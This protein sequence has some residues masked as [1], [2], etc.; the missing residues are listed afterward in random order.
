MNINI[1]PTVNINA[2]LRQWVERQPTRRLFAF[3]NS[4]GEILE[5]YDYSGFAARVDTLAAALSEQDGL[6]P[7]DRVVLTYQPGLELV[8]A[9]FACSKVGLVPIPT[10]PLSAFDFVAWVGRVDHIVKD[11][12]AS[13]WLSCGKT[14]EFFAEG[15]PR[16]TDPMPRAAAD[17]LD[18]LPVLDTSAIDTDPSAVVPERPHP[19]AFLQYTSGSTSNP[20]GV[21][22]SHQNLIANC[23]A[24]VDYDNQIAVTWLPQHHDMGLIGYYIYAVLS[25]G[26]TWGLSPRSFMQYPAIWLELLTRHK[27]TATSVPN[28]ALEL[29]LN[30]R[31]VAP[32]D[33]ERYDLSS[34]RMLMVA[35]EPVSPENFEAFRRKFARCGL[36][37]EAFFAAYGLAE[38]T[39]A[40]SSR[41]QR[42]VSVDRRHLAQGQVSLVTETTGVS[43]ALPL[44][45]CGRALGDTDI[46]IVDPDTGIQAADGRT[47]EIWCAGAGRA[48]GYWEKP[49]ENSEIFDARLVDAPGVDKPFLRTGDIGFMQDD[50]LFVCGRLKDMIII[51]GQNIYPEDIEA[52]ALQVYP[53]LRRNGVVAFSSGDAA[54]MDITL[55]AEIGR[56]NEMPDEVEIVR[57]IREGLQVP[58]AR[59]VFVPPRSIARTSSGKV[60][61]AHTRELLETG[62]MPVLVDTRHTLAAA[63]AEEQSDVYELEL[64][65]DRYGITGEED[66]TLFDAGIDSLDLVVFLN[67]IKDSL[68]DRNAPDL[69]ERVNPRLLSSISIR[70]LFVLVRQFVTAPAAATRAMAEFFAHAYEARVAA[71]KEKMLADR[72]YKAIDR[73]VAEPA[74]QKIGTLI[75]GGTGFLGPFLIDALL[76]Q[77]D[78]DLHVLV[79]GRNQEQARTRLDKAFLENVI[80][81]ESRKA[82]ASRVHVILGDLET[83]RFGLDEAMWSRIAD[84]VDAVYHNGA[85]VNYLLTYDHMRAANVVGTS[86]VLD[87]C[88]SGRDK[89]LNHI[90]T[91]FIF[92]WAVKDFLYESD[93]NDAMDRLDFGYSQ[94]KWAAEQKVFSAMKQGL[95]ARVFRPS[96]ITPALN[97]NGGNLDIALRLLSFIVKHGLGV[98][99]GNQV[100][101]MPA[102]ISADNM[103]AIARQEETLGKTFHVVRDEHETMPMITD[104]IAQRLGTCFEMYDL[105]SFVRQVIRRCTRADPLYP[106]LDFLVGSVDNISRMEFKRYESSNYQVARDRVQIARSDPPLDVVVDGILRFLKVRNLL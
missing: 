22:V 99:A 66:Y 5:D 85:L 36:K 19:I 1:A 48:M 29:C 58:V 38:F 60:R 47:G 17:R 92:G 14:L 16:H 68:V 15:R 56:G 30:E 91:T 76:R 53:E 37:D 83:P 67:W 94:T 50:E 32:S 97:G 51:R 33:L 59:V 39:L 42:A 2:I 20:K 55:V 70:D 105:N 23:R 44:M 74:G 65:K 82:Y 12:R 28:F 27:A 40:V 52:L 89:V 57:V 43:H 93:N 90:S 63:R 62:K 11:S 24:V 77:S 101:F 26:T 8:A 18:A 98:T 75:T 106:L 100:S 54:E 7:G 46:R 34:L 61:R 41:G 103:I 31:H 84:G 102:D 87:L 71:E 88:F 21:C 72:S 96:L 35:A 45:S 9:L 3:V 86:E 73:R 78:E 25:G 49:K 6:R 10:P 95:K 79:R 64:L 81:P 13:L 69:A 104:I 80:D 4:R